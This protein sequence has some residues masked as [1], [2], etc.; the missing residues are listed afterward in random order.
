M[1]YATLFEVLRGPVL[2][3]KEYS[4]VMADWREHI[5]LNPSVLSGKPVIKGTRLAVEHVL[6]M[7]AAGVSE[8]DM[9]S[10]HPRLSHEAILACV[11]YAA[12]ILR[13][14]RAFPIAT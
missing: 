8:A 5:E 4:Y 6:E 14:E 1:R 10:N 7:V 12:E 9:L 11:A 3:E 2:G 13:G